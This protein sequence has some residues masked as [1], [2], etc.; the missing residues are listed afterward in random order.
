MVAAVKERLQS[1]ISYP[2]S[3]TKGERTRE[4]ISQTAFR[5][6]YTDGFQALTIAALAEGAGIRR[7]SY[8]THFRDISE[9]IETISASLLD[10]IGRKS[11][12]N[13]ATSEFARSVVLSRIHFVLSLATS[14]VKTAR[15]LSELY[16]NHTETSR[17]VHRRLTLDLAADRRRGLHNATNQESEMSAMVIAS[18]AMEYLRQRH[19]P[20]R[21]DRE[22]FLSVV[23]KICGYSLSSLSQ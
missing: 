5:I 16:A 1:I 12:L 20:K 9:V 3:Q 17:Q 18:G 19:V 21:G 4:A 2:D 22:L 7:N 15:A 6:L 10:T 13:T 23:I 14:D 11:A 8:Y